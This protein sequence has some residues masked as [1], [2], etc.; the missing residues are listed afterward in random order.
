MPSVFSFEAVSSAD[1]N[2]RAATTTVK[3][4]CPSCR[5]VSKPMPRL[6]PVMSA[7]FLSV[8]IVS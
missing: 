1:F 7:T 6:A 8:A 5:A 3:P 4:F 2:V